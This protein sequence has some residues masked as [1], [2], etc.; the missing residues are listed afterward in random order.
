MRAELAPYGI[1]VTTVTPGLMRTGSPLNAQFKGRHRSEFTW[2]ALASSLPFATIDAERAAAQI[3]NACR[4]GDPHLTI[5]AAARAA[6]VADAI[7]PGLVADATTI[8]A[9]LLPPPGGPD[10]DRLRAGYESRTALA[11]SVLTT[12][13][14]R[15]AARNNEGVTT[16]Y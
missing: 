2:F 14:N 1:V 6:I 5:T 3:L 16:R 7:V 10:G 12:L 9:K 4:Y 8:A 15:A 13:S 11:P